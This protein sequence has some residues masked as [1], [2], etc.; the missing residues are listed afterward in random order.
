MCLLCTLSL[1]KADTAQ[2]GAGWRTSL[3]QHSEAVPGCAHTFATGVK[4]GTDEHVFS[5]SFDLS[6]AGSPLTS[7]VLLLLV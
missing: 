7:V 6:L 4:L 3:P 1:G 5:R 2:A